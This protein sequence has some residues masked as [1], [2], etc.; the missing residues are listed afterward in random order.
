[1]VRRKI[2]RS[3]RTF[4]PLVLGQIPLGF[5]VAASL[6]LLWQAGTPL[7]AATNSGFSE[8]EYIRID[9]EY[10]LADGTGSFSFSNVNTN[11]YARFVDFLSFDTAGVALDSITQDLTHYDPVCPGMYPGTPEFDDPAPGGTENGLTLYS[12][13]LRSGHALA[14]SSDTIWPVLFNVT[15]P[16]VG[17]EL[18]ETAIEYAGRLSGMYPLLIPQ[19]NM[20]FVTIQSI[21]EPSA[22]AS[23][24]LGGAAGAARRRRRRKDAPEA[25]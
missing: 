12:H 2:R 5:F 10:D 23:M 9:W 11:G 18:R 14:L 24:G 4:Q 20:D 19:T 8:D 15:F 7:R 16:T 22:I 17:V 1:M 25:V 3:L 21:P 6:V 13:K